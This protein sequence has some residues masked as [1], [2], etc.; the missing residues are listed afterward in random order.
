[1]VDFHLDTLKRVNQ[2][3]WK[4]LSSK[5]SSFRINILVRGGS[6]FKMFRNTTYFL[7]MSNENKPEYEVAM[8][9]VMFKARGSCWLTQIFSRTDRLN[10]HSPEPKS[11]WILFLQC[12]NV[13]S[14]RTFIQT[15]TF[16]TCSCF[17]QQST[18][19]GNYTIYNPFNF[20][21]AL[22]YHSHH[23]PLFLVWHC[24]SPKGR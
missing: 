22:G 5:T 3:I 16:K 1:M 17:L 15:V 6:L 18:V 7:L 10:I 21:H 2:S 13:P 9:D 24:L 4:I 20:G 8:L 23:S 12:R 19:S 11:R 14:G